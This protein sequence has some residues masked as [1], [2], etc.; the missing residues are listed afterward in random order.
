MF[1]VI[2]SYIKYAHALFLCVYVMYVCMHARTDGRTDVCMCAWMCVF[3]YVCMY[4]CM[5]VCVCVVVRSNL[6]ISGSS[7]FSQQEA[8]FSVML[9]IS[10]VTHVPH[11][12]RDSLNSPLAGLSHRKDSLVAHSYQ[13]RLPFGPPGGLWHQ[14]PH[15]HPRGCHGRFLDFQV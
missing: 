13:F 2:P 14:R 3:T 10:L 7:W 12:C 4:V 8:E 6:P 11:Q 15:L 9:S 1:H 5:Y